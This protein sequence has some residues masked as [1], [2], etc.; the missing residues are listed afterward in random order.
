MNATNQSK[1]TASPSALEPMPNS[2]PE[3]CHHTQVLTTGSMNGS[4]A[5]PPSAACG[6]NERTN[7]LIAPAAS[8]V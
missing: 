6:D 5:C 2:R 7:P 1:I 8:S 3:F 4:D